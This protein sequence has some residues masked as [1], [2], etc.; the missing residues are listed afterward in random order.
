MNIDELLKEKHKLERLLASAIYEFELAT[1]FKARVG[2]IHV[3][4]TPP[5]GT[6]KELISVIAEV[7]LPD[8]IKILPVVASYPDD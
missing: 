6:K 5:A 8:G 2:P 4:H 1:E 7:M 3:M